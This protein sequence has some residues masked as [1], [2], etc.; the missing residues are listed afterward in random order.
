MIRGKDREASSG[1]QV[2]PKAVDGSACYRYLRGTAHL[3]PL[4]LEN[5]SFGDGNEVSLRSAKFRKIGSG[6][7]E[8]VEIK[9]SN[10]TIEAKNSSVSARL[11]ETL[12]LA[13]VDFL[14]SNFLEVVHPVFPI[15][16]QHAFRVS[17]ESRS[18][19][20]LLLA[21][22]CVVSGAWLS[23]THRISEEVGLSSTEAI[24][25][26]HLSTSIDRPSITVLQAG[27]LLLQ[28]PSYSSPQ[29]SSQ[30]ISF[31]FDL[32]LHQDC[33]QWNIDAREKASRKRLAWAVYAQDKW[34]ALLHGRPVQVTEANWMVSPLSEDDFDIP[35]GA[36]DKPHLLRRHGARLFMQILALS[37]L[38]AEILETFY[39]LSAEG[40]V[41]A[42]GQNGLR[43][44]LARAKPVQIKLK[45]WFASLPADMKMD[46]QNEG[47]V[48]LNGNLHLA[49]FATEI[50]LHRC[51]VRASVAPGTDSYLTHICRSAAK[52]RLISAMDFV[53]RLR[54]MH[55]KSCWPIASVPNFGLIG[56]FGVLLRAT[57]LTKEE[58]SFYSARLEEYRWT[59]AVS[60]RNAGFLDSALHLLDS[61]TELLQYVPE[62]PEITEFVSM[63]PRVLEAGRQQG[64]SAF[65]HTQERSSEAFAG[66]SSPAS[67]TS[68]G[69]DLEATESA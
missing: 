54:P 62:K 9:A 66:F 53:N 64:G 34:I 5:V 2:S 49:Y 24:L 25:W 69:E 68:S 63:N 45:D 10:S 47:Q 52:T 30:L 39:T 44:V 12:L 26:E 19:D 7:G 20:P 51:I 29:L 41:R 8:F 22:V 28:C 50:T 59:V 42:S 33:S 38:L 55:F 23:T 3:D 1:K 65:S 48:A 17:Y 14:V 40:E 57:A 15:L 31:A 11:L 16:D 60:S 58:A 37:Q 32:G 67:S 18:L 6:P 61:S 43:I 21:A 4:L 46:A 36:E 56:S 13:D 35:S 27:L